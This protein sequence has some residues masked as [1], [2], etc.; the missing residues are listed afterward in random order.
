VGSVSPWHGVILLF[1]IAI[2]VICGFFS[3]AIAKKKNRSAGG[4]FALG[5]FLG[6]IGIIVAAVVSPGE[7]PPPLGMRAVRCSRCNA[8]Q[9]VD[10]RDRTFE[11]WQCK[12]VSDA[13]A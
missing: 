7:P 3:A 10:V 9:N 1:W 12:T 5:F 8:R 2:P 6:I 4:F 11:C 13:A